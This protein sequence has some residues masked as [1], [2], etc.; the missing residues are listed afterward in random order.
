MKPNGNIDINK[1]D[2]M[3]LD[4]TH[5]F[6]GEHVVSKVG[7]SNDCINYVNQFIKEK[8]INLLEYSYMLNFFKKNG[9]IKNAKWM[10]D[11][12]LKCPSEE[13][14]KK[15]MD[16]YPY[17]FSP[18]NVITDI[19]KKESS[20]KFTN[21]QQEGIRHVINMLY[22]YCATTMGLF[23]FAGSGKTTI[24][25]Y[26]TYYLLTNKLIQKVAITAPTNKAVNIMKAK[27]R[28]CLGGSV[29]H[30]GDMLNNK[31]DDLFDV[32]IEFMTIH[33]LLG[34]GAD[35]DVSGNRV[36]GKKTKS[37]IL[38]YDMIIIDECSMLPLQLITCIY[39][40]L[41][42][43]I[44]AI[45]ENN[46][47]I[48][49][50]IFSG[51]PAQ[52]PP[53]NEVNSVIFSYEKLSFDVFIKS[54]PDNGYSLTGLDSDC[55]KKRYD[56]LICDMKRMDCVTMKEI[57]R[58]TKLN[59]NDMCF[60][61][62]QWVM[63]EIK[64]PTLRNYRGNGVNIYKYDHKSKINS[65]WF[66][67]FVEFV[68]SPDQ[69]NLSNII[70]TWTNKQTD[71]YNDRVRKIIFNKETALD[72][73][74][75]GDILMLNEFYNYN[76]VKDPSKSNNFYTSEQ[77]KIMDIQ[78]TIK[79]STVMIK[80]ISQSLRKTKNSRYIIQKYEECIKNMNSKTNRQYNV[81]K[82][83][84]QKIFD[85]TNTT[86]QIYVIHES[87]KKTIETDKEIASK[88]I[89]MLRAYFQSNYKDQLK[90]ID[91]T[92]I[93]P[94]WKAFDDTFVGPFADVNYGYSITTHKS[95][96]S[97][98]YNVFVDAHDILQNHNA[99]ETKRCIYTSHTRASNEVHI[100]V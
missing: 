86:N 96:G 53:V 77:I 95:Q 61:I 69:N 68:K 49:K 24:I 3:Q 19:I 43:V 59:V 23:G 35:F 17:I 70:I 40:E 75:K 37:N 1:H 42:K 94:L 84:V 50:I 20:L 7:N 52:L 99:D 83:Q 4:I 58:N 56:S 60:N 10:N 48:P 93:K 64:H 33:K 51:D 63:G 39:E 78:Q 65:R 13:F 41:R 21:D 28:S 2:T 79:K 90:I 26:I 36:F 66:N 100:L 71:E 44:Q 81:W 57:V 8:N 92:V 6:E 31:L 80:Q 47:K 97:T 46:N 30:D 54:L 55:I 12:I 45:D 74:E 15:C 16:M 22:D 27:F 34:M 32:H 14:K 73:F 88:I 38:D 67:K 85:T 87:S 5:Y 82:M 89:N 9:S 29:V 91:N 11:I 25:M 98:F 62:R 72:T 18:E 76:E